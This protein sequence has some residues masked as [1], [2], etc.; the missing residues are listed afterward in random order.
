MNCEKLIRIFT[1]SLLF[2]CAATY[3]HAEEQEDHI[4]YTIPSS[5]EILSQLYSPLERV[6]D[7]PLDLDAIEITTD[8]DHRG[9]YTQTVVKPWTIIVYMAAD[10]DLRHFS[11]RNINQMAA[12]GSNQ[13]LNIFVHL[14]IKIA[15]N[16]KITRRY[17]IEKNKI[18]HVNV[19]DP[20]TQCMDSGNP[21]T[22]YSCC[23]YAVENFPAEHIGLILWNHG[24]GACDPQKGRI[25]NPS[26]F[27]IFNPLTNRLE[28]DRSI[29]FLDFIDPQLRGICWDDST[30]NYLTNPVLEST[31]DTICREILHGRKFSVIGY[32]ACLMS[33]V[34]IAYL[35]EPY[36]EYMFGSQEVELGTGLDYTAALKLFLSN[37]APTP[38]ELAT[39]IVNTYYDTYVNITSDFTY[40]AL[41]LSKMAALRSNINSVAITLQH[42]FAH[43]K[44]NSITNIIRTSR[45]RLTCTHFNEPSY[46]DL[47]H[48]Y[49][50][51][52]ANLRYFIFQPSFDG[53]GIVSMLGRLLQE[54]K[55]LIK[56]AVIANVAGKN[57]NRAQGISIYFPEKKLHPSYRF[58]PFALTNNWLNFLNLYLSA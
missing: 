41:D 19:D 46:L 57:L 21:Q 3:L 1:F 37:R 54:G 52:Q 36:A 33:M 10:N 26:E 4:L 43:Q 51:I 14:D 31:L 8:A 30:G 7:N 9:I 50:N 53:S 35:V 56:N 44:D 45:S 38:K 20:E 39:H 58:S 55:D 29:E 5:D 32:D 28:L 12:I 11:A 2:L 27:F 22:L 18:Y 34:E 42:C 47:H 40:S 6:E 17:F 24:T 49:S 13:N 25:I 15:G 23:K 16:K 48:L